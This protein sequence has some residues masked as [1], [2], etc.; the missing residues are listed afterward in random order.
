[1]PKYVNERR[2]DKEEKKNLYGV[3]KRT[4]R[5]DEGQ[6]SAWGGQ[7]KTRTREKEIRTGAVGRSH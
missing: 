2:K 4:G 7:Q 6:M 5:E 1:M 3:G